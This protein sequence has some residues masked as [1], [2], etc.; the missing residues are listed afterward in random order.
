MGSLINN[1]RVKLYKKPSTW[2]LIGII[3]GLTLLSLLLSELLD[4]MSFY[5]Y[6]WQ[7][8]YKSDLEY[9][10]SELENDPENTDLQAQADIVR[11]HLTHD[12]PPTD[13]RTDAIAQYYSLTYRVNANGM[14]SWAVSETDETIIDQRIRTL[15]SILDSGDW[16]G[17]VQL[18]IDDLQSGRTPSANDQEKQVDI[19]IL[20]LYLDQD[21]VPSAQGDGRFFYDDTQSQSADAWKNQAVQSVRANKLA[22]IRGTDDNGNLL[23]N[24]QRAARQREID[25]AMERLAT[26]TPPVE[27]DSFLG[28]L[29]NTTSSLE[30]V[31]LLLIVLAG[32]IISTEFSSGTVKLLLITPHR[33]RSI[34]WA[35]AILLLEVSLITVA[36]IFVL[37]FLISGAFTA[38]QGIGAM[39]VMTLFGQVVR[40]PYLLYIVLR[41]MLMTLPVF[42]YGALA[43][44]LSAVTRKSGVSIAVSLLLMFGSEIVMAMLAALSS[45][46]GVIPG[47]KF[48]LFANTQL[49]NYLPTAYQMW[50]QGMSFSP[51][52]VDPSMTLGFSVV[53]LLIYTVCFLWIARD[54]FCR[55]DIK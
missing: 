40:F 14:N 47:I 15:E 49:G 26:N 43:L 19:D 7:D 11:Y 3:V 31:S 13:W 54:S 2:I 33:R 37:S 27:S 22:L 12:I 44:M 20:T 45:Q 48:L 5:T 52:L 25:V 8:S 28:K 32:G 55:R 23:T 24:S 46:F 38:F 9:Y 18:Q 53:I 39:Q 30:M 21:I 50:T 10:V 16:R 41:C 1:E 42:A 29:E 36:S 17:F 35:K 6:T 4:G 51:S 34:F